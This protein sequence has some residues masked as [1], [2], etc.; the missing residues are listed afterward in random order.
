MSEQA[1]A[2]AQAI[3]YSWGQGNPAD[4]NLRFVVK[5]EGLHALPYSALDVATIPLPA[6]QRLDDP[7]PVQRLAADF[8]C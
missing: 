8:Q 5:V 3:R 6:P 7:L 4:D 1:E 2:L